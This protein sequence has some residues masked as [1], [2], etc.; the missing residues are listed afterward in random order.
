VPAIL[1]RMAMPGTAMPGTALAGAAQPG[2]RAAPPITRDGAHRDAVRELSRHIYQAERPGPVHRI[3]SWV[4]GRLRE[5]SDGLVRHLPGGGMGAL[6][7]VALAV[8]AVA[9]LRIW[10]GPARRP[11]RLGTPAGDGPLAGPATAADLRAA[12]DAYAAR[13]AWAEAVR[14][15]LRAA[16]RC[17]EERGMT[18]LRPGRTLG[19][20][21]T[22]VEAAVPDA[23]GAF[24]GA[25][26]AFG[27]IWYG[28]ARADAEAYSAA[29]AADTAITR[30]AVDRAAAERAAVDGTAS[31]AGAITTGAGRE[32]ADP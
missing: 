17:L 24:T 7:L 6:G 10:L 26:R 8:V 9:G 21:E 12:A 14:A 16:V 22:L 30:A 23:A 28:G 15:R 5:L 32:P 13:G 19:E 1:P 3:E 29:V 4:A 11:V 31:G 27:E 2:V 20:I 25:A 18:E